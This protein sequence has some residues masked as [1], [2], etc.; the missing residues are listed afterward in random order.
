MRKILYALLTGIMAISLIACSAKSKANTSKTKKEDNIS[1][2]RIYDYVLDVGTITEIDYKAGDNLM[3]GDGDKDEDDKTRDGGCSACVKTLD[4]GTTVAGRN[5]DL[6]LSNK[7]AYVFKT[8]IPNCYETINLSYNTGFGPDYSDA[9]KDG[10]S[11][12]FYKSLPFMSTDVM[13]SEGLYMELNLREDEYWANGTNK[14]ISSGT[15]PDAKQ[16]VFLFELPIYVS[17]NCA[18][19]DEALEYINSLNLYTYGESYSFMLADSSG[20]YGL[21]EVAQNKVVWNENQ[22]CQTNFYV[23]PE[24]NKISELKIGCGRYNYIMEHI[25]G[26][27]SKDDM[28]NLMNDLSYSNLYRY[29][30]C[31]FDPLSELTGMKNNWTYDYVTDKKNR[32]KMDQYLKSLKASFSDLSEQK[33]RDSESIYESV[34]TNIVDC[35]N[36][37][38][39]VRFF[40]N[41]DETYTLDFGK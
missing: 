22:T 39:S 15:N 5:M 14:F 34:F 27:K 28:F 16:S 20:H 2:K 36:K 19:V 38:I 25:G 35:N 18:N 17:L 33:K 21:L 30:A 26:V 7:A 40:E 12:E 32:E 6:A 41:N 11:S 4:D 13:N 10:I 8:A 24:F 37:T 3:S 31:K 23:S 1:V 29:P 9:L